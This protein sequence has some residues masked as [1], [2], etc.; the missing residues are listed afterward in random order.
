MAAEHRVRVRVVVLIVA[1]SSNTS[2]A[3]Q[4]VLFD[5]WGLDVQVGLTVVV[6]PLKKIVL[7]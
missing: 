3:N 7:T 1:T 5:L 2:L 4:L 6:A